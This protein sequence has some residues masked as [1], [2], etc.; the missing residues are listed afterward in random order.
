MSTVTDIPGF[1]PAS[2]RGISD[3][4]VPSAAATN[5]ASLQQCRALPWRRGARQFVCATVIFEY[6]D[7]L[8]K[9]L[10]TDVAGMSI[11]N[12]SEP[13]P[14]LALPL[15]VLLA[16]E[17]PPV[18]SAPVDV[19]ARISRIAQHAYRCP[20]RQR[21]EDDGVADAE[22]RRTANALLTKHLNDLA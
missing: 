17:S 16:I 6:L 5:S 7:I 22:S 2:S 10:P 1:L 3:T 21:P 18:L 9:L 8:L 13:I 19:G 4:E 15:D 11:R 12:A 20:C 14:R